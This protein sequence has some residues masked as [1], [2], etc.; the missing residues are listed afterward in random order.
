VSAPA[1]EVIARAAE[2]RQALE[3][4]AHRYYVLDDPEI[5]DD[6]YDKLL[7]ELREIERLHPSLATPDSP[8]Q[9]VGGEPVARLEKVQH[10]E[11]MLSLGNVRS[12][13]EL[14][15][16]VERMRNHLAREGI[17]DPSFTFV[18][19]PKI[20]GLAISLL[21]RDGALVRGATRGNGEV[22]ED[23]T[24]NLRTIGAIPLHVPDAP[25]LLEVRGE[26]Y[27]SLGDFTA[28]NERRAEAGQ[29]TFMNP[30]NSAA[31]TIRQLDPADAAKRPLSIWCYQVGV[32]E[33]LHFQAHSQALQWLRDHGFRVNRGIKLLGS[34]DEVIE[35]CLQWERRRGELDFEI[36][37]A[38]VKIDDLELQRRL[39]SVGRDP[40]WAVAWKFPP[41]TAVTRLEKVMWNVGKFGDLRPY[42]VLA[43]VAVGGVTI[44]LA[45]LHNEEDI[46]RKDLRAGEEV[47]VVRA[48][49]VIPQVVS[50]AP[51][52]AERKGRPRRPR[53][54]TRCPFCGTAT[55]K[56]ADSVFTVC[57]NRDCPARAWQL[58]KHFV[59]RGAMDIDGLGEKQVAL[60][61]ERGLV[62]TAADFYRLSEQQ[63]VE[64]E[65]FAEL[66]AR[67]LL[68]AIEASKQ[69]PFARVL[70][71]LG[72]E[73]VG[74]VTGRNLAQGFRDIDRLL[75]A[76]EEEIAEIPGIG[77]KMA[78]SIRE[79]LQDERMRALIEDLRG[80]GL[81]FAEEG[82]PPSE[83]PLAGR[84]L[85][86]TGSMPQWSR[87]MA[88]ERI[89]AAG[90]RVTG[91]VS[92]KTDYVVAGESPGSK[93]EKAER[94]GVAVI[95]EVALRK[96]LDGDAGA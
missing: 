5:G 19:E 16:W 33:G 50:P 48:G 11:P 93:L 39:G 2:L 12:E 10:L 15:A 45:T 28:L 18:V 71:A 64:L 22:G 78:S 66:S 89:L 43:P 44:K 7:D 63:L 9:R 27:M 25:P 74:E 96:L 54:P 17:L 26:L 29:S 79:Q 34:A 24:H 42:A 57:P 58:L 67:N 75:T 62:R 14:R 6:E 13:E 49:D 40:R 41:T 81:R 30:R 70:F 51:H 90:G 21:Y 60:L 52:V 32:T 35:Q 69:R 80:V 46:V 73:E 87:E 3:H 65:G 91:S 23:V 85:V 8:T 92:K 83:G 88:T 36:D 53:P 38:V 76:S 61:Q 1:Q 84:T 47:I 95:D 77:E 20:D 82:P 55:V 37:G 56:P 4:H 59:S 68:A 31:G 86:L 72:I 94:L